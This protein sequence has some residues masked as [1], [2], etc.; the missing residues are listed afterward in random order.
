MARSHYQVKLVE[1]L[2]NAASKEA[3]FLIAGTADDYAK[4]REVVGYIR[5]LN[6]AVKIANQIEQEMEA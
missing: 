2:E 5:G 6:D 4:Y 1:K 3:A